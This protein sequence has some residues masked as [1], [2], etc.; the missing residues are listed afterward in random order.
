MGRYL[1]IF[2]LLLATSVGAG[3][4]SAL[5]RALLKD[6]DNA[7]LLYQRAKQCYTRSDYPGCIR[8]TSRSIAVK[9]ESSKTFMLRGHAYWRLGRFEA[10]AQDFLWALERD[11]QSTAA[12]VFYY[13]ASEKAG[14]AD[15]EYLKRLAEKRRDPVLLMMTGRIQP[16]AYLSTVEMSETDVK[17]RRAAVLQAKFFMAHYYRLTTRW[18]AESER[19]LRNLEGRE[20]EFLWAVL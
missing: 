1:T 3:T 7:G 5:D 13:L 20:T 17:H 4:L 8:D 14:K 2:L 12:A 9:P 10:A 11:R 15:F 18:P 6:P 19:L 16:Q